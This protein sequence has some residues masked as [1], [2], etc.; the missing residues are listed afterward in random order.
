MKK[1]I[2]AALVAI[3]SVVLAHG[4]TTDS[5]ATPI[6]TVTKN[7]QSDFQIGSA[8]SR[9]DAEEINRSQQGTLLDVLNITPGIQAIEAGAPGGFGEVMIRG[10]GPSQSLILVNGVKVNTCINQD[11]AP[12]LSYAGSKVFAKSKSSAAHRVRSM[13]RRVSVALFRWIPSAARASL[14]WISLGSSAA[15]PLSMKA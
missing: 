3:H 5:N 1:T 12:F 10:N 6:I 4:Q 11:A 14:A 8:F 13:A 7:A 9:I 15:S 2:L